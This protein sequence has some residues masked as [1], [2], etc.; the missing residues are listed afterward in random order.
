ME[1]VRPFTRLCS[2]ELVYFQCL[3]IMQYFSIPI[4]HPHT[5]SDGLVCDEP[6]CEVISVSLHMSVITQD[7]D[8]A[9][10][11]AI[12]EGRTEVVPLL[13]EAGANTDLQNKVECQ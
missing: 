13:L 11:M 8:S 4:S 6:F 9:L 3:K 10:V 1:V 2:Y 12:R 7:G 5:S